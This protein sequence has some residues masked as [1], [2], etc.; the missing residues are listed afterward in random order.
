[1]TKAAACLDGNR[2]WATSLPLEKSS[3]TV[4]K[5]GPLPSPAVHYAQQKQ[6]QRLLLRVLLDSVLP[7]LCKRF[8]PSWLALATKKNKKFFRSVG[9][10]GC[11]SQIPDPTTSKKRR[12]KNLLFYFFLSL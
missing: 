7:T 2:F 4:R 10:P 9:D 11:L 3:Q 6:R 5:G 12:G 1:M 8:R